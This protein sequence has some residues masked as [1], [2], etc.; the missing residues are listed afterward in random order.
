MSTLLLVR[1]SPLWTWG[2]RKDQ[3]EGRERLGT[4]PFPWNE[5]NRS[6]R[7]TLVLS[8]QKPELEATAACW[9]GGSQLRVVAAWGSSGRKEGH[10][11]F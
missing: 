5:D 7:S 1:L 3:R 2:R 4:E 8:L 11:V 6:A 10:G 9:L